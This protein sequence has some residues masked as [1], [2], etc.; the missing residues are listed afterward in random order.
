VEIL[1]N[2][3]RDLRQDKDLTQAQLAT[4]LKIH[5][6]TYAR[7]EQNNMQMKFPDIIK[8]A[9][10]YNVSIDYIAGLTNDKRKYW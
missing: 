10:F 7:W 1:L 8:I 9:K 2:R 6:T 5:T 3:I 4:I